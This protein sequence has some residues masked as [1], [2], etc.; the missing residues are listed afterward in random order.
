MVV[1]IE[2][3]LICSVLTKSKDAFFKLPSAVAESHR[4]LSVISMM[5]TN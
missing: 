5:N 2:G 4:V 3:I 1:Q